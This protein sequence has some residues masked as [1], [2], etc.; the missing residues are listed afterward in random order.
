MAPPLRAPIVGLGNK[1]QAFKL[2]WQRLGTGGTYIEPF[3]YTA[4]TAL[5]NPAPHLLS[6]E[7]INDHNGFVTNFWRAIKH[8]YERTAFYADMPL[9]H[10]DFV[11][12][13]RRLLHY[14]ADLPK[15]LNEDIAFF[16]P[17]LAGLWAYYLALSIDIG[18]HLHIGEFT[19]ASQTVSVGKGVSI[20][21]ANTPF[22][23]GNLE[24]GDEWRLS[25]NRLFGWF[26]ALALR[27]R[28]TQIFCKDWDDLFSNSMLGQSKS[29]EGHTLIFFDPPYAEAAHKGKTY[30]NEQVGIHKTVMIKAIDLAKNPNNRIIVCGYENDHVTPEGWTKEIWK[31]DGIRLGGQQKQNYSRAEAIWCSPGCI[32]EE[33]LELL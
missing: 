23:D 4:S 28:N 15:M 30:T 7:I 11:A 12:S 25:G 20:G 3:A 27:L 9:S 17:I 10:L 21:R 8:D 22:W 13:E 24:D 26:K 29:G 32:Y 6:K 5:S 2:I 18:R 33:Q 14:Q 16:D 1:Y 19:G 31:G